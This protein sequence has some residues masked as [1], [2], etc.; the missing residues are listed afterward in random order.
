MELP[1]V[2]LPLFRGKSEKLLN[3]TL[4][5]D[6]YVSTDSLKVFQKS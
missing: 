6:Q 5:E 1:D 3:F 4:N 2:L